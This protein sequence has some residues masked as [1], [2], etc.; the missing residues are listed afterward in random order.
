MDKNNVTLVRVE[1]EVL[2][3]TLLPILK[4]V[5]AN[6]GKIIVKSLP[7]MPASDCAKDGCDD[8]ASRLMQFVGD[9]ETYLHMFVC[10]KHEYHVID[11]LEFEIVQPRLT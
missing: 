1:D 6:N 5:P 8:Y 9:D 10:E 3:I 2:D 7:H 11:T 4:L